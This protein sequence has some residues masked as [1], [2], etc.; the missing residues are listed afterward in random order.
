ME[1][2]RRLYKYYL[3]LMVVLCTWISTVSAPPTL[4]R[5]LFLVALIGPA[6]NN[7]KFVVPVLL[8][9]TSVA[10]YGFSCSYM[11]TELY[12][13]LIIV[14]ILFLLNI[15]NST[16]TQ[17][18][19]KS[20]LLFGIYVIFLDCI[21]GVGL[22]NIDY[23]ILII[24]LSFFFV[25]LDGHEKEMYFLSF[26]M[27]SIVL[28]IFFFTYGQSN[29]EV[30]EDGR[31]EWVDPNYMG[32]V[33][34]MGVVLAYNAFINNYFSNKKLYSH[35]CLLAVLAGVIM[36]ILNASRGAFLSM[37][38]AII[39]VTMFA[40]IPLQKKVLVSALAVIGVIC[41]YNYGVFDVL[42]ERIV[43]DDGT[44][45][46]RTLIWA[47]KFEAFL[48]LPL[49]KQCFGLGY[50]GGFELA[51]PGGY[52]FHNDY[53]ALIVDYGYIG[54]LLFVSMLLYPI[55][56]VRR[57]SS[58]KPIVISMILFLL[59]C[60]ATLEPYSAGRLA[61]WYFYMTIVLFARW[62]ESNLDNCNL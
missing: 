49:Y 21:A 16:R 27:V 14:M 12:Y 30:S 9:F 33:C 54:F 15:K 41:L 34:G 13:Y 56:I 10:S 48:E 28:C 60:S 44:G 39:V 43:S 40:K 35:L 2:E 57:H 36:L 19:P 62:S 53:L 8:C 5:L 45:N 25:S 32:N 11:P 26:A 59:T 22:E 46:A 29:V 58:S 51:F 52:G 23:S 47:S 17:R 55:R 37:S 18:P 1:K 6:I 38:V 4:I 24:I 50:R 61:Y 7:I 3:F 20:L 42:Q 31:V